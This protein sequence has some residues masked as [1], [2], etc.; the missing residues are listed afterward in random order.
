MEDGYLVCMLMNMHVLYIYRYTIQLQFRQ[1]PMTAVAVVH[2]GQ[3]WIAVRLVSGCIVGRRLNKTCA[4]TVLRVR[5][6]KR[7]GKVSG[8]LA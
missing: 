3:L 6:H 8:R 4:L 1:I 2:N 5:F 7:S